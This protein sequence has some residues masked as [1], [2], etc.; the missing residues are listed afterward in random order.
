MR[1][2][3]HD[4]STDQRTNRRHAHFHGLALFVFLAAWGCDR[5]PDAVSPETVTIGDIDN[6]GQDDV[7]VDFG[8]GGLWVWLN[9]TGWVGLTGSNPE[10][11]VVGDL[12]NNGR[13]DVIVDFGTAGLWVRLN[14][15]SWVKIHD[16]DSEGVVT[17]NIDGL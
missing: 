16:F 5:P 4:Q 15:T 3:R 11:M 8:A 7:I 9:N 1:R 17:G 2:T 10:G 6:N 13:D 12:D 14:N